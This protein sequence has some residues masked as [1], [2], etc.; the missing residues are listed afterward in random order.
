MFLS[1]VAAAFIV[2]IVVGLTGVGGAALVTPMLIFL[3]H[4][5]GSIAIGSDIVSAV[6]MKV[7][8]GSKHYQ[9][10]TV[11]M[12][13]VKWM[14][15]GS[16][17]GSVSGI[18]LL[19]LAKHLQ[20]ES[21]DPIL[22]RLVGAVLVFISVIALTALAL[23]LFAPKFKLPTYPPVDLDTA[24]G[25][26]IVVGICY[27]LGAIL[28]LTS[29][30]SGSLFALVLIGAFRLEA[31]KLVGTDIIHAA[32]LL[33][34][35]A[36]GHLGLGTVNWN[37]VVPIWIGTVPGVLV[38]AHLCKIVN[39]TALRAGLYVILFTVGWQLANHH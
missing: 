19:F 20:F 3:F 1:L 9:Q 8:G 38:G 6:L 24:R 36:V 11:D 21:L 26:L 5:P 39:R 17:P 31:R 35:T 16:I 13:V 34:V 10:K 18:G 37:L 12:Q 29:V 22:L 2:G 33:L 30:G 4:I 7:V 27:L 32:I 14:L 15:C 23:R 28:G 25:R